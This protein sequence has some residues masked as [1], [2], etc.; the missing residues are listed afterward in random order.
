MWR[1]FCHHFLEEEQKHMRGGRRRS[2]Q[3]LIPHKFVLKRWFVMVILDWLKEQNGE[4]G[5]L[6]GVTSTFLQEF[7][8]GGRSPLSREIRKKRKLSFQM[9]GWYCMVEMIKKFLP[10]STC[11]RRLAGYRVPRRFAQ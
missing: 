1:S 4:S 8:A 7:R 3:S 10:P 2:K 5:C 9:S 11:L 6:D